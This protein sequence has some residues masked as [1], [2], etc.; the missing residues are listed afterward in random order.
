MN[1][2]ESWP[3]LPIGT[4]VTCIKIDPQGEFVTSY[5]TQVVEAGAP[6]PWIAVRARWKNKLV[7]QGPV[8]FMPGDTLHEFF[9]PAHPFNLFSVHSPEGELRGWYAN[10]TYP[11]VVERVGDEIRLFWH[12]LYLDVVAVPSG[13]LEVLDEDELAESAVQ[14]TNPELY[15]QIL[16]ARDELVRRANAREFPFHEQ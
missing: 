6:E 12:D 5:P 16:A 3:E 7:Q 1:L 14:T 13:D 8:T 4:A 15:A 2:R 10:V 9:S 11:T